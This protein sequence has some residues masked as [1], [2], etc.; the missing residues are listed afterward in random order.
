MK[1]IFCSTALASVLAF[2]GTSAMAATVSWT[3]GGDGSSWNDPNNWSSHTIPGPSDSAIIDTGSFVLPISG[4]LTVGNVT[5]NVAYSTPTTSD[6]YLGITGNWT[7]NGAFTL[8]SGRTF[9]L[10]GGGSINVTGATTIT[11]ANI[12][13]QG[14]NT[15]LSFPAVTSFTQPAATSVQWWAGVNAGGTG[16]SL[17]FPNLTTITGTP[18][19]TLYT[20]SYFSVMAENGAAINLPAL[21]SVTEP[22]TSAVDSSNDIEFYAS[23][24][25]TINAAVLTTF[26]DLSSTHGNPHAG[27]P[28][29]SSLS[30]DTGGQV[31]FP[32]LT[33]PVGIVINLNDISNPQQFTSLVDVPL[34]EINSGTVTMPETNINGVSL[35]VTGSNTQLSFPN[36]TS[37]T[38]PDDVTVKWTSGYYNSDT[39]CTLTLAKLTTLT[40]TPPAEAYNDTSFQ[41]VAQYGCTI[42]LPAL[43]TVAESGTAGN[44]SDSY[45]QLSLN[46]GGAINAASLNQLTGNGQS[47]NIGG[48][49]AVVSAGGI[50][51][52]NGLFQIPTDLSLTGQ[53]YYNSS[54]GSVVQ[55]SG[56]LLG[57]TTGIAVSN[58]QGTTDLNGTGTAGSPQL[59]EAM[60][61]D[62]GDIA[63]G[64]TNNFVFGTLSLD[65][66]TYVQVVDQSNNSGGSGHDAVYAESIIV[67]AGTTLDLNGLNVYAR[68]VQVDGTVLHGTIQQ[69]PNAGALVLNTATPGDLA[70]SGELDEW[71]FYGYAGRTISV[72]V[73]PGSGTQPGPVSPSL[74]WANVVLLDSS[75]NVLASASDSSAGANI[76]L[77]NVTLPANGTYKIHINAA[78]SDTAATGNYI[79][80]AYD[81]T[82]HAG[83]LNLGQPAVGDIT[84]PFGQDAWTFSAVAGQQVQLHVIGNSSSAIQFELTGPGNYIAFQNL[85]SDSGLI[86]LP[87][88]GNYTVTVS[89]INGATGNYSFQLNQT[90][91]TPLALG[92]TY[93]GT[94]A[95][96]GQAQLFSVQVTGNNPL[97]V[98]LSDLA[99]A[100]HTELYARFGAAPTRATYD[101]GQNGA[102]SSQSI[103]VPN[104]TAGTWYILVYGESI[105]AVPQN[106]T[107]QA[108]APEVALA[109]SSTSESG[110]NT[111]TTLNLTGAGFTS[112]SVVS[113]LAADGHT[114]YVASSS[115]YNSSTQITATFTAG[116]VPAGTYTIVVT[117]PDGTK[118]TLSSPLTIVSSGQGVLTTSIEV[119][120]PIGRHIATVLYVNYANTGNAPMPA[121]VLEVT[122]SNPNGNG[123]FL[124]LN[125][126][127][128]VSGFWT[129]SNNPYGYSNTVNIL[130][131]GATPGVLAPG[132][133][134][135]VPVY[136]GGWIE[137]QWDASDSSV[138]FNVTAIQATDTTAVNWASLESSL[139]PS[140]ISSAAWH[141]MYANLV[142]QLGTTS[143]GLVQLLDTEATYLGQIGQH[144]SD[145]NALWGTAIAQAGNLYPAPQI[146]TT[147]DDSLPMPGSLSL[148][149]S[150]TFQNTVA[151]RFQ[152][153]IL[154][155]GW[156][157]PWDQSLTVGSDGTV[158]L[159]KGQSQF[160]YQP[161]SRYTGQYFSQPGDHNTLTA[162]GS[163]YKLTDVNGGVTAFNANG[164]LAYV[165]DTNGNTIT[166]GYT[167]SQLTSLNASTGPS[168][169]LAY[170][171]TGQVSTATD[172]AGRVTTY[173][174]DGAGHLTSVQTPDGLTTSYGYDTTSGDASLNALTSV[175]YPAGN[176]IY[177]TYDS[178]GRLSGTS[179]DGGA[180]P[181]TLTYSLGQVNVSNAT[182]NTAQLYYDQNGQVDK[183]V[184]GLG[185]ATY[186][187]YDSN[188]NLI[189]LTNAGGAS[190]AY[191]YNS[192]GQP[193]SVTDFLGNTTSYIY[194]GTD[195]QLSALIDARGNTTQYVYNNAGK[196]L[197]ATYA[198]GKQESYSY[199]PLGNALSF[200]D[201]SAHATQYTYN[202]GGQ[203]TGETFSDNS[204]YAYTY[205]GS[206]NLTTAVDAAGTTTFTYSSTGF[207]TNIAYPNS[208]SLTFSYDTGG[209]R[210]QT[211]DQSGYTVNYGYNAVGQ[212][213]GLTDG[214][215]NTIV[216]YSYNTDG[217]LSQRTNGNGTYTTYQYDAAAN[218]LHTINYAPG[219]TVNSQF[220]D[221][222]NAL[223]L[224]ATETTLQGTWTYTYDAD[225]QL[226]H[227]VFASSNTGAVPNQDL[228]YSYDA[229]GNRT[230]TVINGVTTNYVAN[231]RNQYTSIGGTAYTYDNNGNLLSDGANTYT[232]NLLNQLATVT[233]SSTASYAYDAF[234]QRISSTVNGQMTQF[235]LAPAGFTGFGNV[236]GT[237]DGS[238]NLIAH[239]NHGLQ[240]ISQT[241]ASGSSYY[242]FDNSS[243]TAGLSNSAGSYVN[244]YS[245]LPF[246]GSL[247]S[248]GST[249]NP[250]QYVGRFGVQTDGTG[251]NFMRA[252]SYSPAT[253][254]FTAL[255]P[256][257]LAGGD[258]NFYRYAFNQPALFSDPAGTDIFFDHA[259]P[260][261][262]SVLTADLDNPPKDGKYPPDPPPPPPP[263]PPTVTRTTTSSTTTIFGIPIATTTTTST[264]VTTTSPTPPGDDGSS[265]SSSST[266]TSEDPNALYGPDGYGVNNYVTDMGQ[267][268][269]YRVTFENSPTASAPAQT[270]TITDNLDPNLDWST[271]QLTGIGFGDNNL[272]I[273]A[274]S[275]HYATTI[276]MT[277]N[278]QTFNVAVEAGIHTATGQ[279]YA[280][281]Y[282]IDP[283]TGLPPANVLVGFLPPEDGT[284][285]GEGYLTYTVSPKSGVASGTQIP[286]VANI[287][288]DDGEPLATD[289]INDEDPSEGINPAAEAIVTIDNSTPTAQ[290]TALP[291]YSPPSFNISW[292]GTD[293]NGPG[294]A[295]Y[296]VYVS[297]DG[298][299][300]FTPLLSNTTQTSTTFNGMGNTTYSFYVVATDELGNVQAG[301]PQAAVSTTTKTA[302]SFS[303]WEA[304]Y[305]VTSPPTATPENDGVPNLLKYLYDINPSRP[306]TAAD[307][308]GLPTLGM[309]TIGGVNYLTLTYDE[310]ASATEV[311]VTVLSS[312]DL[313]TW[314]TPAN[315]SISEIGTTPGGDFIMQAQVPVTGTCKQFIRLQVTSP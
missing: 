147:T 299:N 124:T 186:L 176:H 182:G 282:S 96:Q 279:V 34:F 266:S 237:Y 263:P 140:G 218:V 315:A 75:G 199:D 82:S 45:A 84:T 22:S 157:T 126:A 236:V 130:A 191:N 134:M 258:S 59:L 51:D 83:T 269:A 24:T 70:T 212:L 308:V 135:R 193:T 302:Q 103:L 73:N 287:V 204:S 295:S 273:P 81:V 249:P 255:D 37:V 115:T 98:V 109:S 142:P 121:P 271:F 306:M 311:T 12:W 222:Y 250:F 233:G 177:Y 132:E 286:N 257:R 217:E 274:G 46:N 144:V 18:P 313:N 215:G 19:T 88:S 226:I 201:P 242:D 248:S 150:R 174:Y 146:Q 16:A 206:G 85:T 259:H 61:K 65:N 47:A 49:P 2:L 207:L 89:G 247:A 133:S 31:V 197:T 101:Y 294:I 278:G 293:T 52:N 303:D 231:N 64:F 265:S 239:Y 310:Y 76:T 4:T 143:G 301:N 40:A 154:G 196:L 300:T 13:V 105:A 91:V 107:L 97:S 26:Q 21:T 30:A 203:I 291:T 232:Y 112:G 164:T 95:G 77:P 243:N 87:A 93:N 281:F 1:T 170:N 178:A 104:A 32:E 173:S 194:A 216:S 298:G 44:Q 229:A 23:Q 220:D 187:S 224:K 288:F 169:T 241:T 260:L 209:R 129:F 71:T 94:W 179:R 312:T 149:M 128:Q 253:G 264:T 162:A 127:L 8:A 119:P 211:V 290:M 262:M 213:S 7:F 48:L 67:P 50:T 245:Y 58:P 10:N 161:D 280:T 54:A 214:S 56:N 227:A 244:Q 181:G 122:A 307:R 252:R 29:P 33:A 234:G 63:A 120:N 117:Q 180:Y 137:S 272:T 198:D 155:L 151:G 25:G 190:V 9:Y 188:D 80:S 210:K 6:E 183:Q 225:G 305:S 223:G 228:A 184:D 185:H 55:L 167:G 246:G 195:N 145:V 106:Y 175:T 139:Q 41:V 153:G 141:I 20:N 208:K 131:S 57:N 123:A 66:N 69:A 156:V 36:V 79:V 221:T 152:S 254:R 74:Q 304:G 205:D 276:S 110:A 171:G 240:L 296:T 136:Y 15:S 92:S 27:G 292:S 118:T 163:Q 283:S 90:N 42:N 189:Q 5:C 60:S 113:L 35:I 277:Y 172:S 72:F 17:N 235:Q 125:G 111:D 99:T 166:A 268:F 297:S 289:L 219:G 256:T 86:D 100:D 43:T 168:I 78:S 230:S 202:A 285:R 200:V 309:T 11:G 38:Q 314:T 251:V 28:A 116:S 284:G 270:V 275:Q 108:T 53:Q 14:N 192:L 158:T 3:G 159:T 148:S 102:G 238:G 114:T 62:D 138:S 39:N 267:Y 68:A 261:P 160:V 165:L